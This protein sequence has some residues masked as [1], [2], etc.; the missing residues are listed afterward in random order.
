M[1]DLETR[2]W[3]P[4]RER[5]LWLAASLALVLLPHAPR[6]PLWV[7]LG[8]VV[9]ALW[10]IEHV[11]RGVRLPSR[12][13]RV[14]LS[15]AIMAGILASYGTLFGRDAGIAALAV[16]SGMKLLETDTL[17]D[18]YAT[19]FLGFFVIITNFLYSQ[20][21]ATGL[22]M[23]LVVVVMTATLIV[24]NSSQPGLGVRRRLRYAGTLIGQSLPFMLVLFVLFPRIPGPLWGLPKDAQSATTGLSDKMSPGNISQLGLSTAVAFRVEFDGPIPPVSRL[25]WRG[26]VFEDTDGRSWTARELQ[27][28]RRVPK[29]RGRNEPVYYTTTLEPH[30]RHWIFAL[31]VPGTANNAIRISNDYQLLATKR[32]RQRAQ[33][34]L[35]S[36]LDARIPVI[37]PEQRSA[38]L[39]LPNGFHPRA[40]ALAEEWR[41]NAASVDG[42]VERA[43]QHFRAE[44]FFY[45]LRPPRLIGD[46]VDEFLFQSRRGFCEYYAAAF[47]VLMRAGGVPARIVTGYQGG[48]INP[49]GDYL[50][51]RQRDAHAWVEVWLEGRGWVRVDPTAAVSPQRIELGMDA[52]LPARIGSAAFGFE[53][54][55]PIAKLMRGLNHGWDTVN[56][57]WNQWVPGYGHIR[58][59]GLLGRFGLDASDWRIFALCLSLAL[60]SMA[61]GAGL[62][63]LRRAPI[64][65]PALEAYR[66]YC[67][68]LSRLGIERRHAEGPSDFAERVS[69]TRPELAQY[70]RRVTELYIG[71]RY[72]KGPHAPLRDLRR[73]VA[74]FRP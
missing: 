30:D 40:R 32:V 13:T 8:F 1:P 55:G 63:L 22:Y 19:A 29:L 17:R 47:T 15:A 37:T 26:P 44:P 36:Y 66:R 7:S 25:Y 67:A 31:D 59:K 21:I 45:T 28:N 73:A 61:W 27:L 39:A 42:F 69:R 62:W 5:T 3:K 54:R 14:F 38:S 16:L 46:P 68:K 23:L 18:A 11:T 49:L 2:D 43:L 58:Q 52:T 50:I 34:R 4:T 20:S 10:R 33:F 72:A 57:S 65:D 56:N 24:I 12:W 70:V 48:E 71:I 53:P 6:M 64:S 51:V 41:A 9:L 60:I 74:S 35:R